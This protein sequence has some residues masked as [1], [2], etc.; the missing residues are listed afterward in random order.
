MAVGT[1]SNVGD[2]AL[3]VGGETGGGVGSGVGAGVGSGVGAGVVGAGPPPPL[4]LFGRV[5]PLAH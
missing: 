1:I 4:L 3:V 2:G 5:D